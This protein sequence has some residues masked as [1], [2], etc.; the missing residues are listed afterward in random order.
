[1]LSR[2]PMAS[3]AVSGVERLDHNVKMLEPLEPPGIVYR[4]RSEQATEHAH[5]P[6]E[7]P[8]ARVLIKMGSGALYA[9]IFK[10]N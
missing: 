1:M 8:T 2:A 5:R 7:G 10:V 9:A 6:F 4:R 3:S